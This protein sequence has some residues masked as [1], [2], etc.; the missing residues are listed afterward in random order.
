MFQFFYIQQGGN[1]EYPEKEEGKVLVGT[2]VT[3]F[4][5]STSTD[6]NIVLGKC[7]V[8]YALN[9][10]GCLESLKRRVSSTKAK[11]FPDYVNN[12]DSAISWLITKYGK[13]GFKYI[14]PGT[15]AT[16]TGMEE[17]FEGNM[18]NY[19]QELKKRLPEGVTSAMDNLSEEISKMQK[20]REGIFNRYIHACQ[21]QDIG[22][23]QARDELEM[24]IKQKVPA[25]ELL[26]PVKVCQELRDGLDGMDDFD[27]FAD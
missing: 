22:P 15:M 10:E 12:D 17:K 8:I 3:P 25:A 5:K 16:F 13:E 6:L 24:Y 21:E 7:D 14:T 1:M 4:D 27:P 9:D 18:E 23:E 20:D 19:R 26:A 2:W 11:A